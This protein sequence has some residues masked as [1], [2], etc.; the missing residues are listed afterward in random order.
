MN[1]EMTRCNT[2]RKTAILSLITAFAVFVMMLNITPV[3]AYVWGQDPL[4]PNDPIITV[5]HTRVNSNDPD[6]PFNQMTVKCTK[7]DIKGRIILKGNVFNM[8]KTYTVNTQQSDSKGLFVSNDNK[9]YKFYPIGAEGPSPAQN[10]ETGAHEYYGQYQDTYE[11]IETDEIPS[12]ASTITYKHDNYKEVTNEEYYVN[13]VKKTKAEYQKAKV[14]AYSEK[15]S[16]KF[17]SDSDPVLSKETHKFLRMEEKE[18]TLTYT[19]GSTQT[20]TCAALYYQIDQ[21]YDITRTYL[22]KYELTVDTSS[23]TADPQTGGTNPQ[24]GGTVS[25]APAPVVKLPNVTLKGKTAKKTFAKIRWTRLTKKNQ[26]KIDFIQIQYSKKPD[27]SNAKTVKGSK[28][29]NCRNISKLSRKTTYYVRART[30]KG[31]NY[32]KWSNVKKIRT[33]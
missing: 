33:K 4:D 32:G 16:T 26:K 15:T 2:K 23:G 21:Y 17:V 14:G 29:R 3:Q 27:F 24:P 9:V 1:Y 12:D 25:P 18:Y 22:K 11:L 13:G 10:P 6:Q 7:G 5:T 28:K 20:M 31:N 19:D 8:N 30:V